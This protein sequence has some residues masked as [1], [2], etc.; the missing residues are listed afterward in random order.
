MDGIIVAS[1][2]WLT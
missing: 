2:A 1:L